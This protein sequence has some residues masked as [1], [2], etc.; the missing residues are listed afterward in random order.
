MEIKLEQGHYA[1]RNAFR[2]DFELMIKNAKTYNP[3]GSF[4]HM[5]AINLE[6]FFEKRKSVLESFSLH[7]HFL[8]RLGSNDQDTCRQR[9]G[10]KSPCRAGPTSPCAPSGNCRSS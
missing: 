1:D 6:T 8:L 10:G 9:A 3:P 2:K 7:A 5:D 4:V